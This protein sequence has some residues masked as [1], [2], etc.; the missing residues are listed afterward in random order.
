MKYNKPVLDFLASA[1]LSAAQSIKDGVICR[2][3]SMSKVQTNL[4]GQGVRIK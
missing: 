2:E 1:G 4:E 3:V